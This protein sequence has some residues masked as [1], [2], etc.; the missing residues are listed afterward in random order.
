MRLGDMK[1]EMLFTSKSGN[2]FWGVF[3]F[4]DAMLPIDIGSCHIIRQNPERV[5]FFLF[6]Q[7]KITRTT[8]LS[9]T[10][11]KSNVGCCKATMYYAAALP[12]VSQSLN[13]SVS[14]KRKA[15][16]RIKHHFQ[17]GLP[18]FSAVMRLLKSRA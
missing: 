17:S 12:R 2:W 1:Y 11:E 5:I 14:A 6:K 4:S 9:R 10:S 8:F 15:K 7:V 18:F 3:L 16:V 13:N